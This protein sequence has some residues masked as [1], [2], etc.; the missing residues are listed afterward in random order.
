MPLRRA[1]LL[2]VSLSLAAS[3]P[4]TGSADPAAPMVIE[5]LL[6]Q[7]GGLPSLDAS[8]VLS[9]GPVGASSV[10]FTPEVY[11]AVATLVDPQSCACPL[12]SSI[13][14]RTVSFRVRWFEACSATAEVSVVG[15][16]GGACPAPDLGRVLCGPVSH[17]IS[18]AGAV[19]VTYTLPMPDGCCIDEPAFV[20][21]RFTGF[22]LCGGANTP[23]LVISSVFSCTPCTQYASISNLFPALT[24]W[25]SIAESLHLWFSVEA[26]C[27]D[28][29]PTLPGSWGR[30]KTI[31]R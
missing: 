22:E 2:V 8:C 30:L 18:S 15:S 29:T 28:A 11:T 13:V 9:P 20:L 3:L 24:Q 7:G 12:A 14:L 1:L 25:C 5:D 31:Y 27:C 4:S 17:P 21:V 19:G 10:V 6:P 23:G 26:D 16:T